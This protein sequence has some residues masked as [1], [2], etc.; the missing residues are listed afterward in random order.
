M[1]V[2]DTVDVYMGIECSDLLCVEQ[3]LGAAEQLHVL[4]LNNNESIEGVDYFVLSRR[5]DDV[6]TIK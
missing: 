2:K 4:K 5:D 3:G 6:S 1:Y